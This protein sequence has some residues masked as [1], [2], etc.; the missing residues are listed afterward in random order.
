MVGERGF[1]RAGERADAAAGAA[2]DLGRPPPPGPTEKEGPEVKPREAARALR[3][4]AIQMAEGFGTRSVSPPRV[5][6]S[7]LGT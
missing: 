6:S 1:A 5:V 7:M 2:E 3:S 4:G